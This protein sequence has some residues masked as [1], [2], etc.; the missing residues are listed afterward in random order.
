MAESF[1]DTDRAL[2]EKAVESYRRIDAWNDTP[3]LSEESFDRLQTVMTE[4]GELSQRA[5]YSKVVN[6]TFA[7]KAVSAGK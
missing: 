2:L 5:D 6:N 4:A 3:V 1:P 7:E